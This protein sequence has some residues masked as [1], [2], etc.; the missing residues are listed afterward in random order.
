MTGRMGELP[1]TLR[2][3]LAARGARL[4]H[5]LDKLHSRYARLFWGLHSAWALLTGGVVLVLAHNRYGFLPWVVLFLALTWASTL[6]FSR[7]APGEGST[8][9]RFAQGFVSYLTRVMYQETLFF[10]LP[11]YFYSTTFPSWNCLYVIG[12][13]GL[14]VLSCFDMLFDRLL[15]EKR[16]FALAFFAVV[17]FSALQFF[18]PLLLKVHY[19]WG[20]Y[21]AA[22]LSFLAALP[23]AYSWTE[24]RQPARLAKVAAALGLSLLAIRTL[25]TPLPPVPLRLTK[26][27]FAAELDRRTLT[28][29]RDW[30]D[31]V[32]VEALRGGRLYVVATVFAPT[33]LPTTV[34]I[35]F[36]REEKTLRW[37]RDVSLVAHSRGFRI[38]DVLHAGKGGFKP[39]SYQVEVWTDGGQ[40]VGRKEL[41]V[42]PAGSPP[43]TPR[44]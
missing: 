24:I 6:F 33:R 38:W 37:S 42:L 32:P 31:A 16:W 25:R 10:L 36:R 35:R 15:R 14:A 5:R 27:Y 34:R 40:L 2:N 9:M 4:G 17:T 41:K 26:V 22:I 19:R 1:G 11:F 39:G 30:D 23:L 3:R 43:P 29:P 21:L 28:T 44:P 7:L 13:A 18:F 8:A 20:A 12:L